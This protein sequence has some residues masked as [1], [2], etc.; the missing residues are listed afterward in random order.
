MKRFA[1]M[2]AAAAVAGCGS[3]T[4]SPPGTMTLYWAFQDGVG[5]VY[6]DYTAGNSGCDVAGIDHVGITLNSVDQGAFPCEDSTSGTPG[7]QFAR[8]APGTYTVILDGLRGGDLIY[9]RAYTLSVVSNADVSQDA[10]L[11]AVTPADLDVFY[12]INGAY[13]CSS[14][15]KTA[16][17]IYYALYD[18]ATLVGSSTVACGSNN[19]DLVFLDQPLGSGY[20]F[21][22]IQ[23]L[24]VHGVAVFQRCLAGIDHEGPPVVVDLTVPNGE[25]C[26]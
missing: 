18:G 20:Q 10:V 12:T 1:W 23:G 19:F 21:H 7:I 22:F 26:D 24:D 4:S 6:G 5:T 8:L 16:Q 15:G 14:N 17:D 3:S 25:T 9:S 13:S 11:Q 2:I